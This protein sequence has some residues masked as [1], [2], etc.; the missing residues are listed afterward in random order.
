MTTVEFKTYLANL[1]NLAEPP[2]SEAPSKG[3][4][5]TEDN[6]SGLVQSYFNTCRH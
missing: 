6:F 1:S 2:S 5:F 3:D 4:E